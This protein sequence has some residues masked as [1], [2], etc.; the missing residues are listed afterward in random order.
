MKIIG[1]ISYRYY[2]NIQIEDNDTRNILLF[3]DYH[4][5]LTYDTEC[6]TNDHIEKTIVKF[7]NIIIIIYVNI[8]EIDCVNK[9]LDSYNN[10]KYNEQNFLEIVLQSLEYMINE[11]FYLLK[12]QNYIFGNYLIDQTKKLIKSKNKNKIL[13]D[14]FKYKNKLELELEKNLIKL[15]KILL[16]SNKKSDCELIIQYLF[17]VC[18]SDDCVDLYYEF[19][20]GDNATYYNKLNVAYISHTYLLF[21]LIKY[22]NIYESKYDIKIFKKFFLNARLHESDIRILDKFDSSQFNYYIFEN[23]NFNTNQEYIDYANDIYKSYTEFVKLYFIS[24][25]S[26]ITFNS[27]NQQNFYNKIFA[28]YSLDAQTVMFDNLDLL[29]KQYSKSVFFDDSIDTLFTYLLFT[30]TIYIEDHIEVKYYK[31]NSIFFYIE[32]LNIDMYVIFRFFIK[33]GKWLN[34]KHKPDNI[35]NKYDYPKNIIG[36]FGSWHT[37]NYS[38]FIKYYFYLSKKERSIKI[39][40]IDQIDKNKYLE[41]TNYDIANESYTENSSKIKNIRCIDLSNK[42]LI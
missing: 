20:K 24:K 38:N 16:N 32:M 4:H 6:C 36:Y 41:L 3:G 27:I 18:K 42:I 35:C 22:I 23:T 39:N 12:N 5:D 13:D 15:E 14:M 29:F 34:T 1:P 7:T 17:N 9:I 21:H 19:N 40:N 26:K 28:N 2:K 25:I 8:I 30:L 37:L 33:K 10:S 31:S 11:K